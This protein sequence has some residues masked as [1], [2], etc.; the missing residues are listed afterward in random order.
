MGLRNSLSP[1]VMLILRMLIICFCFNSLNANAGYHTKFMLKEKV[2]H[3]EFYMHDTP[4]GKNVT[5]VQVAPEKPLNFS[6]GSSFFGPVYVIDDALT[7]S[8][9]P[10]SRLLGRAQ[11]MY[12]MSSM[13]EVSLLMALTYSIDSGRYKGSSLS[14][15]GKNMVLREQRELPIV[16]GSGHFRMA[17]GY[18]FAHTIS[19]QG[20]NAVIGYNV[21]VFHYGK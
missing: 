8:P 12:V 6:A 7:K 21:T 18:A 16:G 10:N 15:V 1:T 13:G 14:V 5:A 17:R 9:H 11:G 19:V 20:P 3:L 2:T 4:M